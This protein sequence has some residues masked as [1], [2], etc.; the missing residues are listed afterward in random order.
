MIESAA[1]NLRIVYIFIFMNIYFYSIVQ[2][3]ETTSSFIEKAER[4]RR[5]GEWL[6]AIQQYDNCI[7]IESKNHLCWFNKA[8]CFFSLT[9]EDDGIKTLQSLIKIKPEYIKAYLL[10]IKVYQKRKSADSVILYLDK[11]FDNTTNKDEKL[12]YTKKILAILKS[13]NNFKSADK[14]FL[15]ALQAYPNNLDLLYQYGKYNNMFEKYQEARITLKKAVGLINSVDPNETTPIYYE[16][17]Y[18]CYKSEDY[19]EMNKYIKKANHGRYR[20]LVEQ[21]LPE[22][23]F[24]LALPYYKIYDLNKAREIL[25]EVVKIDESF[26]KSYDLLSEIENL[27]TDKTKV[28]TLKKAAIEV[29]SEDKKRAGRISE[30][31]EIYIQIQNYKEALAN[32]QKC[33][34]LDKQ[35]EKAL[36]IKAVVCYNQEK[37]QES[38]ENLHMLISLPNLSNNMNFQAHFALGL[39]AKRL[40]DEKLA[41]ES[42]REAARGN[43]FK[44]AANEEI[45]ILDVKEN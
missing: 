16:Y 24:R 40:N 2:G 14:F 28:I 37:F 15:K 39:L 7:A 26:T 30:L 18:T 44:Y 5:V 4:F 42:F 43:I 12:G 13:T 45:R 31:A 29:E 38:K 11:L 34:E 17:V 8:K 36:F 3:Q 22:Y 35:N 19:D 6:S 20:L 32:A 25:N 9:L 23:N 1:M 41:K 10:L 21:M 27:I 33:L